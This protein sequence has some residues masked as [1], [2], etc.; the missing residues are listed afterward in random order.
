MG[1]VVYID[2]LVLENFFMNFLLLYILKRICKHNANIWKIAIAALIGAL[3]IIFIFSPDFNFMYT[4]LMKFMMS[5]IMIVIAF[6][7]NK[8]K[9]L[10]RIV[11]L[12]YI[13]AFITGG[14]ILAIFYLTRNEINIT[15][16]AIITNLSSG[17][18]IAGILIAILF[19]KLG[20]D[21]FENHYRTE[22]NK[23]DM[24]IVLEDKKCSITALID[25]GN[26]LKDPV[27]NVP[28]IVAY[29]KSVL[30]LFPEE[31]KE[32]ILKDYNYETLTQKIISS[33][34]KS[35]IRII[36]FR[37]LG[38]ENGILIAIRADMAVVKYKNKNNIVFEP[39]IALYD[40]PI[41]VDGDYEALAYP[42][43]LK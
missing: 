5:L 18:M 22:G 29:L 6:T 43:I 8:I 26:T 25:T 9:D 3:Y 24:Q 23:V 36:P 32:Y 21:Y 27:S 40:K 33:S 39:I 1:D 10:I 2:V 37:A 17:Y 11:I 13:E 38:T 15:G 34:L 20:F 14:S 4:L 16:G 7:P 31:L 30:E 28:V 19:V 42:E 35:R 41:S 12:F